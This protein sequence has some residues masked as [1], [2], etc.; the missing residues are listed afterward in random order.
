MLRKAQLS[1]A[2]RLARMADPTLLLGDAG[3]PP[4]HPEQVRV[5]RNWRQDHML[6]WS[7]QGG[8]S[9]TGAAL[10]CHNLLFNPI[11]SVPATVV[12]V[13]RA[14]RQSGELFRKARA[15]F[16]RLPYAPPLTMDS[17]TVM[18]IGN[19]SRILAYPGSE[20]AVRGLSAVTLALIDEA[21]LVDRELRD[22]VS[23]MLSTTN[24]PIWCMA[25]PKGRNGWFW[26]DW[27]DE[28]LDFVV[29]SRITHDQ[30]AH[31]SA[32]FTAKERRRMP[33]WKF[34]QEYECEFLDDGDQLLID[35]SMIDAMRSAEVRALW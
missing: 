27:T 4:P 22:A 33:G 23:P 34:Q 28:D 17:A 24:A 21:T 12:I 10:A 7:R 25:T 29:K 11:T 15:L 14:E 5:L 35:P 1:P 8:K 6:L 32:D 13:S 16:S 31:I 30:L 19:E 2:E 9:T 18:E 20:D 26:E 3:A